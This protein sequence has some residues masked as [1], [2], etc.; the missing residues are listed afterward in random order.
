VYNVQRILA[1]RGRANNRQIK[2]RWMGYSS[3][4]DTWE[5]VSNFENNSVWLEYEADHDL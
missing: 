5:P 2:V 4:Y 1:H 3:T